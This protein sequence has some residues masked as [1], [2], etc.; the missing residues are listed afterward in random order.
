MVYSLI[1]SYYYLLVKGLKMY[2]VYA[3]GRIFS[4]THVRA[5]LSLSL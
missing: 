4:L 2:M 5:D 1:I 3:F